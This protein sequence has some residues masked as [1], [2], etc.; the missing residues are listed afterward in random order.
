MKQKNLPGRCDTEHSR[1]SVAPFFKVGDP[2]LH[3]LRTVHGNMSLKWFG[4]FMDVFRIADP[5]D[6][7]TAALKLLLVT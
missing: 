3:K 1:G 5:V 7:P 2:V 4:Q 6:G